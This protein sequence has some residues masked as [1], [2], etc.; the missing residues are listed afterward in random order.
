MKTEEKTIELRVA[1]PGSRVFAIGIGCLTGK[2]NKALSPFP[3]R[4]E[5]MPGGKEQTVH[6]LPDWDLTYEVEEFVSGK[7]VRWFC[8]TLE[9]D[10]NIYRISEYGA[11]VYARREMPLRRIVEEYP[12]RPDLSAFKDEED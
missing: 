10:D 12:E 4:Y 6:E 7:L 1:Y 5:R 3:Q 9:G 8:A 11:K 2:F